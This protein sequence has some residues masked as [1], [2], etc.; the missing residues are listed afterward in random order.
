MMSTRDG[1]NKCTQSITDYISRRYIH[2][3]LNIL[4]CN[5]PVTDAEDDYFGIPK[6]TGKSK[7]TVPG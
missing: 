5:K 3:L 7:F 6:V 2:S 4:V 1:E